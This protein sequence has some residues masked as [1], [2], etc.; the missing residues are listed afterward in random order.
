MLLEAL[1][2]L[3]GAHVQDSGRGSEGAEHVFDT[4]APYDGALE[5][6]D[7]SVANGSDLVLAFGLMSDIEG[8][9]LG[10]E[11]VPVLDSALP[12]KEEELVDFCKLEV[13]G[14][15]ELA[16]LSAGLDCLEAIAQLVRGIC[17][18]EFRGHVCGHQRMEVSHGPWKLGSQALELLLQRFV[19]D[20]SC[21]PFW[22]GTV[23]D[24]LA[25]LHVAVAVT[26]LVCCCFLL[27]LLPLAVVAPPTQVCLC[28]VAWAGAM[29][30]QN[31]VMG[32]AV[33]AFC[34]DG[35]APF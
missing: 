27:L 15:D 18:A 4:I 3:L 34:D 10:L 7:V 21:A 17:L 25:K 22:N 13:D 33:L 26:A 9:K 14:V 8:S 12:L 29:P 23:E 2:K 31:P 28:L 5:P 35:F 1:N 11:L 30:P 24:L 20:V 6:A 32:V 19:V 16:L